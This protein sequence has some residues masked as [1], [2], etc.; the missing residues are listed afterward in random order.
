MY[1]KPTLRIAA[2]VA[3]ATLATL[4]TLSGGPAR[5][6]AAPADG[7]GT[8]ETI[9]GGGSSL[10]DGIPA[11]DASIGLVQGMTLGPDGDLYFSDLGHRCVVQKIHAGVISTVAGSGVC[12][13]ST[14]SGLA[15]TDAEIYRPA[16]LAF[17]ATGDLYFADMVNCT[18]YNRRGRRATDVHH[19]RRR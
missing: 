6:H 8:V 15:A 9:A 16:G 14:N 7:P 13:Y 19:G 12:G 1:P 4:I 10:A 11:T 18:I 17:D 2:L 3:L 5:G